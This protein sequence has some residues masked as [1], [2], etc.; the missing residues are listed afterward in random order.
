MIS[1]SIREVTAVMGN[2]IPENTRKE[3]FVKLVEVEDSGETPPNAR[4]LVADEFHVTPEQ[5]K[6]IAEEGVDKT[7]PPLEECD[8]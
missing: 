4:K 5:V 2:S 6:E 7:W 8:A 3:I 1:A